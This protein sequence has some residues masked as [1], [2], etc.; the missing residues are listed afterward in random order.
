MC[1]KSEGKRDRTEKARGATRP[2]ERTWAERRRTSLWPARARR[3]TSADIWGRSTAGE[4]GKSDMTDAAEGT[5]HR[6]S[7]GAR[8]AQGSALGKSA[9]RSSSGPQC[10]DKPARGL[11]ERHATKATVKKFSITRVQPNVKSAA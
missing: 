7:S 9:E 1:K 11:R 3:V 8:E 2:L 6:D 5:R 4:L 10:G